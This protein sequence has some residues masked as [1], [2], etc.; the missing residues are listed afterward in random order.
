MAP[1]FLKGRQSYIDFLK[2]F[3]FANI[4]SDNVSQHSDVSRKSSASGI[5]R[6]SQDD[7]LRNSEPNFIPSKNNSEVLYSISSQVDQI[8][9]KNNPP[10]NDGVHL[11]REMGLWSGVSIVV[12][13]IIGKSRTL[14]TLLTVVKN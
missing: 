6:K 1:L 7:E 5:Q 13:T 8:E 14:A 4:I 11:K 10:E 12:G 2:D 3:G 9:K